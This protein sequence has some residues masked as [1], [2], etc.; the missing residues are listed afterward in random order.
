MEYRRIVNYSEAEPL[1]PD[2]LTG[3]D[4]INFYA[5]T[6]KATAEQATSI[7][8]RLDIGSYLHHK[9]GSYSSGMTKKLSLTLAFLGSPKLILLDEPL[10]TLD[11]KSLKAIFEIIASYHKSGVCIL[12]ASHQEFDKSLPFAPVILTLKDKTVS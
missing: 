12:M 1:Y 5:E 3:R 7:I 2:F 10:I 4:L 6:K 9:T 8:E 11:E